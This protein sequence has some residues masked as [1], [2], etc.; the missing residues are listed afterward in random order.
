MPRILEAECDDKGVVKCQG[1]VIPSAKLLTA[2]A[3][4]STG[5]I[6]VDGEDVTYITSNTTDLGTT[7]DKV[8][9]AL[10]KAVEG[11]NKTAAGLQSLDNRGFLIGATAG[12]PG[13]PAIESQIADIQTAASDIGG[14]QGEL[15]EL[16]GKLK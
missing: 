9:Q 4:A 7:L 16:K 11:L 5:I 1:F 15:D 2:G 3:Q 8:A 6:I 13:P 14:L 10:G 12:V